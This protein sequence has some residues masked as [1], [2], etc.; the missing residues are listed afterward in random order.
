MILGSLVDM[1]VSL[2]IGADP[3]PEQKSTAKSFM[4]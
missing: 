3:H 4:G 1:G 2:K